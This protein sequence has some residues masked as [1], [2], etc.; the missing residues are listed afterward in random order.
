[1]LWPLCLLILQTVSAAVLG[2]DFGSEFVKA[3]LVAPNTPFEIVLTPDSQ[4]K[5]ASG[6]VIKPDTF[7][8]VYGSSGVILAARFPQNS[9][10]RVKPLLGLDFDS[11]L[12]HTFADNNP[13]LSLVPTSRNTVAFNIS[14][15]PFP[16][17]E[18]VA[19]QLA[20][21]LSR[22]SELL[23]L[24]THSKGATV[25]DLS[26]SVPGYFTLAQR[27]ALVAAAKLTGSSLIGLVSD[28][29][30]VALNYANSPAGRSLGAEKRY[31]VVY[32]AG[33]SATSSTLVS[34]RADEHTTFVVVEGFAHTTELGGTRLTA[35]LRDLL[36]KKSGVSEKLSPRALA[37]L[38]RECEKAKH[39]LSANSEVT[40]FLEA[41]TDSVDLN[42][43]LTRQEFEDAN[44]AA[45]EAVDTP[46]LSSLHG[47]DR[48]FEIDDLD[49]VVLAGG[50]TRTPFV[51]QQLTSLVGDA[52]LSKNVNA[53]E[54][55]V[56]GTTLRGVG[57]SGIFKQ[58]KAFVVEDRCLHTY[59]IKSGG[60]SATLF[61]PGAPL[62][63]TKSVVPKSDSIELYEDGK[64]V[65]TY[66]LT[67]LDSTIES[68]QA[69]SAL[70]CLD[71]PRVVAKFVLDANGVV[72]LKSVDAVCSAEQT[73]MTSTSVH[74]YGPT[75]TE[76][77]EVSS[78]ESE[79]VEPT[80]A[81]AE[82][83]T[84]AVP[85]TKLKTR[86]VYFETGNRDLSFRDQIE[87]RAHLHRLDE[88][89]ADRKLHAVLHHELESLLYKLRSLE[90]EDVLASANEMLDWV[91]RGSG[92]V[93]ELKSKLA[94]A[95]E[96]YNAATGVEESPTIS[97]DSSP[98]IAV[99]TEEGEV[100]AEVNGGVEAEED[101]DA[102]VEAEV[103]TETPTG[104]VRAETSPQ[105]DAQTT[106]SVTAAPTAPTSPVKADFQTTTSL[107]SEY[108]KTKRPLADRIKDAVID[109][110]T[111][112]DL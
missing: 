10:Y 42:V 85:A 65:S 92:S 11:D 90:T 38:W 110:E 106:V 5:D 80:S 68:I 20:D 82:P 17:E 46:L 52:K 111:H 32:D 75:P 44:S 56:Q 73:E 70:N 83:S 57:L 105:F 29:V 33:A 3:S 43:K 39:V 6:V 66:N 27:Q 87:L 79:T 26:V 40:V 31:I 72:D 86:K 8:R 69:S 64:L 35:S 9:V 67:N 21:A 91:E 4:R 41:L 81:E 96:L 93:I 88:E 89:D 49:A 51:L 13:G 54:A 12:V 84:T 53:D 98:K 112:D 22:S 59:T 16:V 99:E 55:N 45:R 48:N 25:R 107:K 94:Q 60:A 61:T 62:E 24:K 34:L 108:L 19:M 74:H 23:Q 37:R 28:G 77:A 103:G 58:K 30:A 15:T 76:T 78:Q 100:G 7:E 63:A 2:V 104:T 1:M 14:G 101:A 95:R 109:G 18:I 36:L 102:D 97:V 50:A 47:F 71:E